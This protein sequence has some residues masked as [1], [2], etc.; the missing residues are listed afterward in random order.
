[1]SAQVKRVAPLVGI[2]MGSDSDLPT[3]HEVAEVL[4]AFGVPYEMHVA[5]AHRT[6]ERVRRYARGAERRGLR[7]L[8]AGAGSAAHLAGVLAAHVTLPVIGI[9]MESGALNG[10]DAL[11]STV[12]MPGGI[13]VATVAIGRAGAR[14]AGLLAVQ[15]LALSDPGLRRKLREHRARMAADVLAKDRQLQAAPR[16]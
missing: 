1:M 11:L 13:P 2:L 3:M 4:D 12:Q 9:P 15:I 14:N 10:L 5:S 8:I 16:K 6:P 7:L